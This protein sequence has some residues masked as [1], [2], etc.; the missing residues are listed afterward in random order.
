MQAIR[1]VNFYSK[2]M[3]IVFKVQLGNR[4][5]IQ[6]AI[7]KIA[8]L[9]NISAKDKLADID[10]KIAALTS[11]I[12]KE[13]KKIKFQ[14]NKQAINDN[15]TKFISLKREEFIFGNNTVFNLL[16]LIEVS[17]LY[18]SYLNVTKTIALFNEKTQA[19]SLIKIK[20]KKLFSLLSKIATISLKNYLAKEV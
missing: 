9:Y 2:D 6:A 11:E 19:N 18:F 15:N 3:L 14:V 20:R 17:D 5:L 4:N 7:A 8:K 16:R 1:V 10:E 12:S 13:L